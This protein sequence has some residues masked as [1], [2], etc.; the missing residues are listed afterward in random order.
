MKNNLLILIIIIFAFISC[1]VEPPIQEDIYVVRFYY[2]NQTQVPIYLKLYKNDIELIRTDTINLS[3]SLYIRN[4]NKGEINRYYNGNS[5]VD[6]IT[7][8][9]YFNSSVKYYLENYTLGF[10]HSQSNETISQKLKVE[11]NF[12]NKRKN[13]NF[14]KIKKLSEDFYFKGNSRIA[15]IMFYD[16][17]FYFT[18]NDYLMADSIVK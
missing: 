18:E 11:V 8:I 15:N 14:I 5:P 17:D 9:S 3:D 7:L 1:I 12:G 2:I 13:Q 10:I 6:P 16:Y 4:E